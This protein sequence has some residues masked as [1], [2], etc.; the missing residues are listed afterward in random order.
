M[1]NPPRKYYFAYFSDDAVCA[2]RTAS[3][4]IWFDLDISKCDSS[5]REGAFS[6]LR[7]ITPDNLKPSMEIAIA[8]CDNAIQLVNPEDPR[9]K[10]IL[11]SLVGSRMPSGWG[12]TTEMNNGAS[13]ASCV[14]IVEAKAETPEEM[15]EATK[16]AGYKYTIVPSTKPEE[17]QFLK[18]SPAMDTNGLYRPVLNFGV[19]LRASGRSKRDIPGSGDL[20]IRAN[21]FMKGLFNGMYP[22]THCPLLE[23]IR[24]NFEAAVIDKKMQAY[25]DKH[26]RYNAT[27]YASDADKVHYY[28][29]DEAF[30]ERYSLTSTEILDLQDICANCRVGTAHRSSGTD[31]ILMM[32][33]G[34]TGM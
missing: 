20:T 8:Q 2:V 9:Q 17:I 1:L 11:E 14:A 4:V 34:L 16:N 27:T 24:A 7:K 23:A 28:F 5:H 30:L 13:E 21:A 10:V 29:T 6:A 25:L 26:R 19:F 33:Y 3:G 31:K 12:G 18:H 15:F 32:D 22:R